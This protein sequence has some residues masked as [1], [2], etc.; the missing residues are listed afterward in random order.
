M[1]NTVS[2]MEG[3]KSYKY[4]VRKYNKGLLNFVFSSR[5]MFCDKFMTCMIIICRTNT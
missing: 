1:N 2:S 3:Y 4:C 5:L